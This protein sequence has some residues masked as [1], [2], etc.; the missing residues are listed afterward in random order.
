MTA[1]AALSVVLWLATLR[2]AVPRR[3]R[4]QRR[5][6]AV[7]TDGAALRMGGDQ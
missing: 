4:R 6:D 2:V 7:V 3:R 5:N 1:F